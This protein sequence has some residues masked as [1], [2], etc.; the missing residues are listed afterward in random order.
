MDTAIT[1]AA[2]DSSQPAPPKD[3]LSGSFRIESWDW[4]ALVVPLLAMAPLLYKQALLLLEDGNSL[5]VPFVLAIVV[6]FAFF[7]MFAANGVV[8]QRAFW[9]LGILVAA[10][11]AYGFAVAY[12]SPWLAQVAAIVLFFGWALGRWGNAAWPHAAG[13]SLL[14]LTTLSWPSNTD[15][16]FTQWL[17]ETAASTASSVLDAFS[18]PNRSID[19]QL[20]TRTINVNANQTA[21]NGRVFILFPIVGLLCL[22]RH[23]S[24]LHSLLLVL[25]V[26]VWYATN[27]CMVMLVCVWLELPYSVGLQVAGLVATLLSLLLTDQFLGAMLRPVPPTDPAFELQ[28]ALT[29]GLMWWPQAEPE[30]GEEF[31]VD[32]LDQ[33]ETEYMRR[34]ALQEAAKPIATLVSWT[35]TG[36][37]KWVLPA[38]GVV[39]WVLSIPAALAVSRVPS[40]LQFRTLSDQEVR[41]VFDEDLTASDQLPTAFGEWR[42]VSASLTPASDMDT[43]YRFKFVWNGT[44]VDV[45]LAYPK[46][47]WDGRVKLSGAGSKKELE[48]TFPPTERGWVFSLARRSNAF[49]GRGYV[50]QT[51]INEDGGPFVP[52]IAEERLLRQEE[53]RLPIARM[54]APL[55]KS[56]FSPAYHV[57]AE[58]EPGN[59][60]NDAELVQFQSSFE[61][62][63]ELLRGKIKAGQLSQFE[64]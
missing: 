58:I 25:F 37:L 22:L 8:W 62:F 41:S 60:L 43:G 47:G 54:L 33:E 26:P 40:P 29:N 23:R 56:D 19:Q 39:A 13:V 2:I 53:L 30:L 16:S 63:C 10:V 4:L 32:E 12:F 31:P 21:A 5:H 6:G 44:P 50:W 45:S 36:P 34:R 18:V 9:S 38:V 59:L 7:N 55:L 35:E 49:G 51:A 15:E 52:S 42:T 46:S 3:A 61:E 11:V 28:F 1:P 20:S 64:M 48:Q 24:A 17:N 14:L 57:R 27:V